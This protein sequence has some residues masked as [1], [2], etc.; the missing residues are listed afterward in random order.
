MNKL[1]DWIKCFWGLGWFRLSSSFCRFGLGVLATCGLAL[2][3]ETIS[4]VVVAV[5]TAAYG[6]IMYVRYR[7]ILS[8]LRDIE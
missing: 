1:R 5:L 6:V 7:W 8:I 3:D 4:A 2:V